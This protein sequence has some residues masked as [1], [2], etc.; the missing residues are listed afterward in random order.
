MYRIDFL[1]WMW[2]Y[3]GIALQSLTDNTTLLSD[4]LT[5]DEISQLIQSYSQP[6]ALG[7]YWGGEKEVP[8]VFKS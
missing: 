6:D 7:R 2:L 8:L 1:R 4:S 3:K 5:I